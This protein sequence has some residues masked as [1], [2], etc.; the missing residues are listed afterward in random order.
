MVYQRGGAYKQGGEEFLVILPNHDGAEA[1]AFVEK[2]RLAFHSTTFKVKDQVE[3]MTVSIDVACWPR[4]G[5]TYDEVLK[6]ANQAE[7]E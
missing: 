5:Q 2:L 4:H 3:H 6:K 1:A 7:V